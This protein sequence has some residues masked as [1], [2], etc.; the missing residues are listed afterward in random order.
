MQHLSMAVLRAVENRRSIVR[1]TASGQTCAVDPNGKVLAMAAPFTVSWLSAEVP[2]VSGKT[3]IYTRYGDYL[4]KVFTLA[5]FLLLI[6][7]LISY[8]LKLLSS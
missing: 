7:G 6:Q 2:I 8:I 3:T 5:A 4:G 1:S